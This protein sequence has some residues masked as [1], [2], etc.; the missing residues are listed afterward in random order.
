[1]AEAPLTN[2]VIAL[3]CKVTWWWYQILKLRP[4]GNLIV[5]SSQDLKETRFFPVL[6]L[7]D[8]SVYRAFAARFLLAAQP[9]VMTQFR[10][11]IGL[12]HRLQVSENHRICR[13]GRSHAFLGS[14]GCSPPRLWLFLVMHAG[15]PQPS[16]LLLDDP[17]FDPVLITRLLPDS[18]N[19][20]SP[21][22]HHLCFVFCA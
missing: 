10:R 13:G 3:L 15:T 11:L 19:S 4:E 5:L 1:M 7:I 20:I 21:K 6:L 22:N 12:S 2:S 16:T 9:R 17:D 14:Q 18:Q 8:T